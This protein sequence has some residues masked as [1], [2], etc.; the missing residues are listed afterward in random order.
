MDDSIL[1]EFDK[2]AQQD[3]SGPALRCSEL[4]N[5]SCDASPCDWES[6][7]GRPHDMSKH[8][9]LSYEPL[10]AY[11]A[12]DIMLVDLTFKSRPRLPGEAMDADRDLAEETPD[13]D[14]AN[15]CAVVGCTTP[16]G[17]GRPNGRNF[18]PMP[19]ARSLCEDHYY[20]V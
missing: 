8:T 17:Q 19:G 6:A 7:F 11:R 1:D 18:A 4:V 13:V 16:F 10:F 2:L 12:T 5:T 3:Y 15:V 9:H 14:A 20:K